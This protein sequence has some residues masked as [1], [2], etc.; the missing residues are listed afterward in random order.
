MAARLVKRK[1]TKPQDAAT[2]PLERAR[3]NNPARRSQPVSFAHAMN[4]LMIEQRKVNRS[5]LQ[6]LR[7][8]WEMAVEGVKGLSPAAKYAEVRS[9]AKSGEVQVTVYNPSIA[10]EVGVVYKAAILKQLREILTGKDSVSG[11]KVKTKRGGRHR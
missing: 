6:R 1:R 4:A 3:E 9:L 5:R 2:D 8:A 7:A 10:H 11:I